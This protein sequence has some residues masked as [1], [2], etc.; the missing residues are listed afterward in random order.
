MDAS[1][2]GKQRVFVNGGQRGLQIELR[3]DDIVAVLQPI[4]AAPTG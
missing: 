4:V 2:T 3:P 1:A